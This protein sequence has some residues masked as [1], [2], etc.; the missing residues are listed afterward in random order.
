[1]QWT[2]GAPFLLLLQG[3]AR[4]SRCR[5][6][7]GNLVG[8]TASTRGGSAVEAATPTR[9]RSTAA[10][11]PHSLSST[12][13]ASVQLASLAKT[14][15]HAQLAD[16]HQLNLWSSCLNA[17][18]GSSVTLA[19]PSQAVLPHV[20]ATVPGVIQEGS[21]TA[22]GIVKSVQRENTSSNKDRGTVLHVL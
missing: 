8:P 19:A 20:Q 16:T 12:G 17:C 13:H 4:H 7:S 2:A 9:K 3:S 22:R 21:L 6:W 14:A 18:L 1:M 10:Q 15:H 5:R 11:A